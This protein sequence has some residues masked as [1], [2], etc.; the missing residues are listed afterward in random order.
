MHV[1]LVQFLHFFKYFHHSG[2]TKDIMLV[3]NG[4]IMHIFIFLYYLESLL[5]V[6]HNLIFF[7][8]NCH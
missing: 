4:Y 3:E 1:L 2:V 8:L 7:F 6:F 5:Y